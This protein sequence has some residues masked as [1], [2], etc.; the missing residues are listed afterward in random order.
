MQISG[1]RPV[2]MNWHAKAKAVERLNYAAPTG[3][4]RGLAAS[5]SVL[6]IEKGP[7]IAATDHMKTMRIK[8]AYVPKTYRVLGTDVSDA[9]IRQKLRS[10]L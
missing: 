7:V 6:L 5:R 2:L 3:K 8:Y 1:Q 4:Q 10:L 9:A